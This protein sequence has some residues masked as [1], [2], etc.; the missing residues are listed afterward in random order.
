MK[1]VM[2]MH[3]QKGADLK[4]ALGISTHPLPDLCMIKISTVMMQLHFDT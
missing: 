4:V 3:K 1:D 2:V